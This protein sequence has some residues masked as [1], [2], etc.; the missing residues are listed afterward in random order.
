MYKSY[1]NQT[2]IHGNTAYHKSIWLM[3]FDYILVEITTVL[4][5]YSIDVSGAIFFML[6]CRLFQQS[7]HNCLFF[8]N[9]RIMLRMDVFHVLNWIEITFGFSLTICIEVLV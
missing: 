3:S 7:A 5:I 8:L 4:H 2:A 9:V 1:E 6:F